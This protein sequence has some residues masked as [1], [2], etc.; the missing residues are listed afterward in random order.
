MEKLTCRDC[1][2]TE[3]V[4][5]QW[6]TMEDIPLCGNCSDKRWAERRRRGAGIPRDWEIENWDY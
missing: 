6:E 5:D 2:T 1:G 3:G 4:I